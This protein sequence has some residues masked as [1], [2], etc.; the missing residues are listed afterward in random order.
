M[1]VADLCVVH[2]VRE[3][4]GLAPFEAFLDSYIRH[5]AGEPHELMLLFKGFRSDADRRPYLERAGGLAARTM[6]V[7]DAGYDLTAYFSVIERDD[8]ER[9]CFLNSF[10]VI[11]A[12]DW[13]AKLTAALATRDAGIVGATGSWASQRSCMLYQLGFPN[14]YSRAYTSPRETR[15]QFRAM[16]AE[17]AAAAATGTRQPPVLLR[18]LRTARA[19]AEQALLFDPF[20]AYHLRTNAFMATRAA[21]A[22]TDR[23]QMREKNHA[24]RFESGSRN[25]T[26]QIEATGRR[27][28]V[29]GRDGSAYPK[30]EW[31]RSDTFWQSDQENLLVADNQTRVYRDGDEDLRLLLSRFAW[32]DRARPA[33]TVA[34]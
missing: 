11:E 33:A 25:L 34:A 16:T 29:V 4:N 14:A 15:H 2:L 22:A 32:A 13:L 23:P 27:A 10:S 8:R 1:A 9:Y 3:A 20:P 30:E 18:K 21:L 7:D 28:L 17:P 6:S 5:P 31:D 12:D 26:K 24:Y 19:M